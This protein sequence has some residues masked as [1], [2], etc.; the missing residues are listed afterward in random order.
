MERVKDLINKLSEQ[1]RQN[2]KPESL[3]GTVQQLYAELLK[4]QPKGEVI[5]RKISVVMPSANFPIPSLTLPVQ[6]QA[7]VIPGPVRVNKPEEESIQSSAETN[8]DYFL[9]KPEITHEPPP[10][11]KKED[12]PFDAMAEVPTLSQQTPAKELHEVIADK[13]ESLNDKLNTGQKELA[14][15]LKETPIKDLRKG[16]GVNDKF[17]FINDL[18]RGDEAMYERSIKTINGF[19]ILQEAEY[20]MN[21]ELKVKLGWKEDSEIVKHFYDVVRRRFL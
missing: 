7:P 5:A 16:I 8:K 2:E 19:T 10:A 9:R 17:V 4:L 14:H 12:F 11:V 15:S 6:M 1:E 20:W 18:F 21:R 13:K 3:L